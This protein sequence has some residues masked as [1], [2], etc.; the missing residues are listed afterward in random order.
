MALPF[1]QVNEF[2]PMFRPLSAAEALVAELLLQ[3]ASNWIRDPQ[4]RPYIADDDP[5]ARLVVFE[6]VRDSLLYGK[7]RR[8]STFTNTTG[9]RT[10][11]GAWAADALASLDFTD[12]HR[13]M[14]GIS[15]RA[16]PVF[17]F[18]KCDY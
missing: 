17:N 6:V 11:E 15:V 4:R 8:F 16:A 3:V 14:L 7:Y 12:R 9:H 2:T 10:E 18:P 13:V 1:L 5:A